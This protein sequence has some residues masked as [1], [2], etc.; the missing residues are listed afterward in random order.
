MLTEAENKD[1]P[2][3]TEMVLTGLFSLHHLQKTEVRHKIQRRSVHIQLIKSRVL[4][5]NGDVSGSGTS[6][7]ELLGKQVV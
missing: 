4:G 7:V 5:I 6:T 1:G 3:S 2:D